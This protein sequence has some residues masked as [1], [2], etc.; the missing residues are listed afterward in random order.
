MIDK[1]WQMKE[2]DQT[3]NS[4]NTPHTSPSR[5]R[6]GVYFVSFLVGLVGIWTFLD[7]IRPDSL[8]FQRQGK[9]QA[10]MCVC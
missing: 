1:L 9:G 5:A 7:P 6:Y 3:M 2:S 8:A 10:L 4:Q